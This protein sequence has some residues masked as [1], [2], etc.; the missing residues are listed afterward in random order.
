MSDSFEFFKNYILS[1]SNDTVRI[2]QAEIL[3]KLLTEEFNFDYIECIE[4]GCASGG[5]DNF[6]VYLAK[7]CKDNN[8][9][10]STVD[11]SEDYINKSKILYHDVIGENNNEYVVSDSIKFLQ[12]YNGIP[13]LVHLDSYDLDLLNPLP[14]ML[15]HWLEFEAIQDKMPSGS[16]LLIDDNFFKGTFVS[17]HILNNGVHTDTKRIDIDYDIIGK[18]SLI[19][20]F[21]KEKES[22]WELIGNHYVAGPNLKLFFRKK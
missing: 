2:Q 6:G 5:Y 13:N 18:G 11:I 4:T 14:S 22:N 21:V 3:D 1:N 7:Y 15:H 8:G 17:W 12:S 16:L 9:K 10:F 19:Y 20:H